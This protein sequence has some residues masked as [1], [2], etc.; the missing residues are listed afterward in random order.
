MTSARHISRADD[1]LKPLRQ[2][3]NFQLSI[4]IWGFP[5]SSDGKE[6]ACNAGDPGLDPWVEQIPW[7]SEWQLTPVFLPGESPGQRSLVGYSL[8]VHKES[9]TTEQLTHTHVDM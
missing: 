6:S 3:G 5:G 4:D 1:R 2:S 8:W 7:R 9:H